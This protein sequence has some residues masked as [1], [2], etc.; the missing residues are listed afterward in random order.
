M[1]HASRF[2]PVFFYKKKKIDNNCYLTRKFLIIQKYLAGV[3]KKVFSE[4]QW[5]HI[6]EYYRSYFRR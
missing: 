5:F 3:F 6:G 1:T 2:A 4:K